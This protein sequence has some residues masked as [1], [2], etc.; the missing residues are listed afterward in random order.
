MEGMENL[1]EEQRD[2]LL[3][4]IEELQVRDRFVLH[5]PGAVRLAR[6]TLHSYGTHSVSGL[7]QSEDIQFCRGA[8]LC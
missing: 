6:L 1:P 5:Y 7:T 3:Q 2:A 8:V 4:K